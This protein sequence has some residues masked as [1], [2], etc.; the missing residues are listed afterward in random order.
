[1]TPL[2]P[3]Y[4]EEPYW[5][6]DAAPTHLPET[7]LPAETDVVIIGGGYTGM[8][9]AARLAWRGRSVTVLER[10]A[11]GWGASSRNGGIV[12]PGFKTGPSSLLKRYGDDGRHLYQATLDAMALV[13][14][15][16]RANQIDC[17]YA[18]TGQLYLSHKPALVRHLDEEAHILSQ[19]FGLAAWVIPRVELASEISSSLYYSGLL[20]ERSG[21][22]HPQNILPA[23]RGWPAIAGRTSTT[24]HRPPPSSAGIGRALL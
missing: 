18:Q 15:T 16:I 9:A 3:G 24:T 22:L 7:A 10:N 4:R 5:W 8:M 14:E 6:R 19:Q 23:L 17:Q 20:V 11:L 2:A 21:G 1:L 12:L 13:E